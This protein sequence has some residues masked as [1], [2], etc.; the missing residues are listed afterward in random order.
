MQTDISVDTKQQT[1]QGVAF[2]M[3]GDAFE[4]LKRFR[5]KQ[6]NY[7]QLV[8][9][10]LPLSL[11]QVSQ[12]RTSS[13]PLLSSGFSVDCQRN[14]GV[15]SSIENSTMWFFF[16]YQNVIVSVLIEIQG[17]VSQDQI[18]G[19]RH[20]CDTSNRLCPVLIMGILSKELFNKSHKDEMTLY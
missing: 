10:S 6:V 16:V 18:W 19:Q 1:L 12:L 4:A 17:L 8:S 5:D 15:R 20:N 13:V 9:T 3:H 7:V 11:F 2:P 14:F